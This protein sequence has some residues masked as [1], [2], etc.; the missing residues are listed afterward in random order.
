MYVSGVEVFFLALPYPVY[1]IYDTSLR[2]K[3]NTVGRN[4][5]KSECYTTFII[6]FL[7][8]ERIVVL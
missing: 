4:Y 6:A 5:P 7:K 1:I 8:I 3:Y 2:E